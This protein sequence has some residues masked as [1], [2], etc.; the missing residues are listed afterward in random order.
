MNSILKLPTIAMFSF[1]ETAMFVQV[2][3]LQKLETAAV[4]AGEGV[5]SAAASSCTSESLHAY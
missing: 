4:S 5:N 1:R 3:L 2:G